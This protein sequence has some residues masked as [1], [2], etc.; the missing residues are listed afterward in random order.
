VVWL[1]NP[2]LDVSSRA[3][4]ARVRAGH[5]VRYLV[6]EAVAHYIARHRLYR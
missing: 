4:R 6:P 3:I 2:G 1:R 5:T